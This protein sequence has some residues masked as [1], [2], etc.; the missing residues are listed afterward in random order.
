MC[1]INRNWM[2]Y[3][4]FRCLQAIK[5]GNGKSFQLV[6]LDSRRRMGILEADS[7]EMLSICFIRAP[8]CDFTALIHHRCPLQRLML[9]W[10]KDGSPHSAAFEN[11]A[12]TVLYVGIRIINHHLVITID[13]WY[14]PFPNGWLENCHSH[15]IGQAPDVFA[16]TMV[17][18]INHG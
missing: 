17:S 3:A 16:Y 14:T 2:R 12:Y 1:Q 5:D 11:K 18:V 13:G 6:T 9:G 4:A 10:K 7:Q 8:P 15:M